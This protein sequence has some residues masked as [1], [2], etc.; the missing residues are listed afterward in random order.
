[1]KLRIVLV[2]PREAGNVGAAARVMKNF[3][4]D[5]LWIV[6]EHPELLPV[7]SWW[8][9]GADDVLAA[10]RFAPTL[11]LALA[12]A[13]ITI[14]T[15]AM[16]GR[17]NVAELDPSSTARLFAEL[18]DDDT[19]AIVFGREDSGLT[20]DEVMLCQR[21]AS[22]PTN[23]A[24]PTMNLAQS[25]GVFCYELSSVER[26]SAHRTRPPAALTER[27][28]ERAEALLLEVGFLQENNPSRLYDEV[29]A[30]AGRADLDERETTIALGILRQIEWKLGTR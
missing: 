2:E 27:L 3:G 10:A 19:L 21:A 11:Q 24:F 15:T 6:G 17:T 20:R 14:A 30:I 8:G 18:G 22:I 25:V 5:E 23:P 29:R 16:R 1:M 9:S 13:R 7:A 4:F 26:R 12:D 28:H